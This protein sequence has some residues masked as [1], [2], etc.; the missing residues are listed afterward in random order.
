LSNKAGVQ[1]WFVYRKIDGTSLYSRVYSAIEGDISTEKAIAFRNLTKTILD[2]LKMNY[3]W[4]SSSSRI[5]NINLDEHEVRFLYGKYILLVLMVRKGK[6][7]KNIHQLH[8]KIIS[9]IEK[10][11]E[12]RLS[13][14]LDEPELLRDIWMKCEE[15]FRP[16][17]HHIF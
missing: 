2:L 9:Y 17:I 15:L 4:M 13:S 12:G 14:Q 16:H 8:S 7:S 5:E 6:D 1:A 3:S 10:E 11:A